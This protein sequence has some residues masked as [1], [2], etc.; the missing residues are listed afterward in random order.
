MFLQL[1]K[2]NPHLKSCKTLR[3]LRPLASLGIKL[4]SKDRVRTPSDRLCLA[5]ALPA[6]YAA[7]LAVEPVLM[8]HRL[9]S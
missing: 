4:L 2:Y 5:P 6:L 9:P 7:E 8:A 1:F 3:G